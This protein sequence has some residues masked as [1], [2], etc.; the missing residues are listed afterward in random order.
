M[1]DLCIKGLMR[2]NLARS[3]C[4]AAW[5]ELLRQLAYKAKWY[6]RTYW[7]ADR[8]FA[9]SRTRHACGFKLRALPLSVREWTCPACGEIHDRDKTAAKNILAAGLIATATAGRAA[10]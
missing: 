3:I 5:G 2:T 1:E 4:D 7:Q 9:S 10:S 6:G 8:Y